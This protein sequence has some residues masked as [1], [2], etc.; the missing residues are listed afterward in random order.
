MDYC[1]GSLQIG[2]PALRVAGRGQRRRS[3]R[4]ADLNI[5]GL[6]VSLPLYSEDVGDELELNQKRR[7]GPP[8]RPSAE[9]KGV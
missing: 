2:N 6:L 9:S 3:D 8:S 7:E 4:R 1:P 5:I